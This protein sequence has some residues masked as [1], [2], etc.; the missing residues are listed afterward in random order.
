MKQIDN[1]ETSELITLG[2]KLGLNEENIDAMLKDI[3]PRNEQP[4]FSLGPPGYF[5]GY[6]GTISINDFKS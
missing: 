3:P 1:M 2:K 5:G 4:S 6:Y